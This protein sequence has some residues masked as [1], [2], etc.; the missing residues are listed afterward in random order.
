MF[1]HTLIWVGLIIV[2][3]F[4]TIYDSVG[5]LIT[6]K[7]GSLARAIV[8]VSRTVLIWMAAVIITASLG[9]DDKIFKW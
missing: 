1:S 9:Q 4:L 2:L 3:I 5:V 7:I 8:D 6:K